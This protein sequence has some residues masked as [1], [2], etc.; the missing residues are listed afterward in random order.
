[1][2]LSSTSIQRP[3]LA[4]VLS[5]LILLFGVVGFT[6]LGIREYPL[7]D[8]P[9]V[10]VTT[11]YPG[12]SADVMASQ[13]TKP[14]E[15]SV[16]EANGIRAI[17]SVSQEQVSVITVEFN[18]EADL[19]AAANDVRDKVSKAIRQLPTDA[20]PPVVEKASAP[21]LVIFMSLQ[22]DTKSILEV[23]HLAATTIKER[24]QSIP[25]VSKVNLYGEQR[26]AMRLRMDPSKMAAYGLTPTDVQQALRREN[27][28]LP[29]GRIEGRSTELT[30]RTLGRLE[31]AGQFD[32]MILKE[33]GGSIVRFK[34]IGFAE[35]GAQ[36]ERTAVT[37]GSKIGKPV[38]AIGLAVEPQRGA[39]AVAI[40]DEFYKR[41]AALKQELPKEYD[42]VI[43][44]DFTEN[45]RDS[46]SE[47]QETLLIAFGL[48]ILIIFIFL[49]DWRSTII[50]VVA[51]PV[52]IVSAFFIM[53]VAG[54]SINV[55]PR[56]DLVLAIGGGVD[57]AIVVRE[58]FYTRV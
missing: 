48:V 5:V 21:D 28:D 56:L 34:D 37:R 11:T 20:D 41:Y 57:D 26:Y 39:N 1:M 7:T 16:A 58:K 32:D 19:E 38:S 54:F 2:S 45:I 23:S 44:K 13:I 52:S 31:M 15:E 40:A 27:V 36:N 33:A 22:S 9:I 30:I 43:G 47:V 53:Y 29:A 49:R 12:A 55:L 42:L 10:T 6:F 24:L 14:L 17:S 46:I 35:L 50:P 4:G 8:S 3:V 25:G 51:I 18:L